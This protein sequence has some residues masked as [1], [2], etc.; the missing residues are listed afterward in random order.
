[1]GIGP[2]YVSITGFVIR[3]GPLPRLRFWW[4]AV[5]SM[6]QAR[7]AD[8][9]ISAEAR[10]IDGVQHTLTVWRDKAAMRA[11]L[12]AGAHKQAMRVH[13]DLGWG[14]VY[15]YAA[16]TPPAWDDVPRLWRAHGREV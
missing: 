13:H 3:S 11:Y 10:A 4:Y 16:E 6:T 1:M 2:V 15:G 12:T 7:A 5:R 8:G 14:K 9:N